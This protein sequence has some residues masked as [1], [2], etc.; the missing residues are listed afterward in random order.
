MKSASILAI[1]SYALVL[2]SRAAHAAL[3]EETWVISVRRSLPPLSPDCYNDRDMLLVNGTMPG[4]V[5]RA[6]VGDTVRIKIIN[7][8]P[9]EGVTIHYHG[10][11][12][13]LQ[14][15]ADGTAS[16]SQC[17]IDPQEVRLEELK[18]SCTVGWN[19]SSHS[20]YI[21]LC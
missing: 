21:F 7:N 5:L 18:R 10:I 16:R 4:P 15:Y 13:Y 6:S 3:I 1:V 8:S 17:N 11:K 14:P 2:L 19:E 9:T 20:C 12:M